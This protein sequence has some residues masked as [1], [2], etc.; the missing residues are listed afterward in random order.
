MGK[1]QVDDRIGNTINKYNFP[2]VDAVVIRVD[3]MKRYIYV[4][5]VFVDLQH[6]MHLLT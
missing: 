6:S 2:A 1:T 3:K 5:N 4:Y